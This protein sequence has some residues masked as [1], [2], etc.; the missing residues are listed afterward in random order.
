MTA[1]TATLPAQRPEILNGRFLVAA[2]L[3]VTM[4]H[5]IDPASIVELA[6]AIAVLLFLAWILF[7]A[8]SRA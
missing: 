4:T 6:T 5:R 7:G 8:R 1:P 3:P 2:D